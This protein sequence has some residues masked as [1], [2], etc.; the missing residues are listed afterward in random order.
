MVLGRHT[1]VA[2]LLVAVA[3]AALAG[4]R[5]YGQGNGIRRLAVGEALRL[6]TAGRTSHIGM[7][8]VEGYPA[9]VRVAILPRPMQGL[10]PTRQVALSQSRAAPGMLPP[11]NAGIWLQESHTLGGTGKRAVTGK[12]DCLRQLPGMGDNSGTFAWLTVPARRSAKG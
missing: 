5:V 1:L 12:L 4:W 11:S 3:A 6:C 9:R 2:A 7:V 8:T 10:F